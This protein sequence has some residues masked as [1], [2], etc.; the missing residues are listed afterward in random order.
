[1]PYSRKGVVVNEWLGD[2]GGFFYV[3]MHVVWASKQQIAKALYLSI[4]ASQTDLKKVT[5][6]PEY[7]Y[8]YLMSK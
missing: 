1:M 8:I 4:C 2:G 7:P 3:H 5:E 6:V